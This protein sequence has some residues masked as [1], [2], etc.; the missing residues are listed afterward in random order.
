M[1]ISV[2]FVVFSALSA[3][4]CF[5][6][7]FPQL[8]SPRL[9][10]PQATENLPAQKIGPNDLIAVSVY[11]APELT[12]TVRVS[13]EGMIRL[14]MVKRQL[15]AEGLMPSELESAIAEE[16]K[17]EELLVDPAVTDAPTTRLTAS[18]VPLIGLVSVAWAR[19]TLTPT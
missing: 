12:R 14:P 4:V 19:G 7:S 6:Q 10:T 15:H 5:P 11:D 13:A 17:T 1:R 18:T 9:A 8:S 2:S 3:S 16:L